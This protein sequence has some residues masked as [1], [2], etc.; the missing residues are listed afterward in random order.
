MGADTYSREEAA[1]YVHEAE[2]WLIRAESK[3]TK[4]QSFLR[5]DEAVSTLEGI[6]ATIDMVVN[7]TKNLR[8]RHL[9][10]F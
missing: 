7:A 2:N 6:K 4:A 8:Q 9:H 3:L 5:E 10:P 1:R